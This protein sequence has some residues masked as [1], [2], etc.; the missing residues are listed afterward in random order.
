M[1]NITLPIVGKKERQLIKEV[2]DSRILAS[3][4]YVE[5]FEQSFA[6]YCG[7]KFGIANAN[8]TSSLH[9]SLLM[10]GIKPG[11]K[12]V[13]TPFSFIATS[14]SILFCRAEPVFV[15]IDPKTF[16][17]NPVELEK[18]L[19]M[20]K[21][22]KAVLVV[23]LYGLPCDMDAILKL[24]KKYKFK[25]IEDSCQ[26]HGAEFRC[27]KVGSFG[28]VAAFSFYTTK[29]MMTGEGGIVLTNDI[30]ADR[31]GRQLINHGRDRHSATTVLGYNY[32]LTNLAAAIG[33]AQF[34]QLESRIV[35]RIANAWKYNEAF[36]DLDFLQTPYIPENCR[37]VFHQYTVR[38]SASE[39]KKFIDYLSNNGIGSGIYYNTV[40][41]KQPFYKQLGYRSGLCKEAEKAAGEVLS[42]PVHP[43]LS[44]SDTDKIIEVIRGYK[45]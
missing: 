6:K 12:V 44:K 10:C 19:K 16:N 15:D 42:L 1:I 43:S 32:R 34:E 29:N 28:D 33:I 20:E 2:L 30:K 26:A 39:R 31:Y 18:T 5:R 37:H 40:L 35:K 36:K 41:Y 13:T 23:H 7:V 45:K 38:I 17:I 4:E 3:G 8:G 27:R 11:D 25:L 9:V 24:K 14:N 21:N 22:I